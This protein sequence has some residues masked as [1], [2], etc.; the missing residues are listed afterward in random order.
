MRGGRSWT[1]TLALASIV[2][3]AIACD[4]TEDGARGTAPQDGAPSLA[5]MPA[6]LATFDCRTIFRR[7]G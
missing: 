6:A 5:D 3:A 7:P 1:L 2:G 4:S